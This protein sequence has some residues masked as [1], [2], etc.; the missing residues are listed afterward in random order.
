MNLLSTNDAPGLDQAIVF[1]KAHGFDVRPDIAVILGSGL[2]GFEERLERAIS[3]PYEAIPGF[4][5]VTVPGH[6]GRLYCGSIADKTALVFAG[7]FHR[8]EGHDMATSVLPVALA[9]ALGVRSL[10]VSNAAG[11]IN[12][13]YRVGDLM[14]ITGCLSLVQTGG[15]RKYFDRARPQTPLSLSPVLRRAAAEVDVDLFEGNYLYVTG[16]SYETPAEVRAFRSLGADA[17]G[18]STVP[19][20]AAATQFGLRC[21]AVSL[22]T[23][24]ASGMSDA[25]LDHADIKDVGQR[26]TSDFSRLVEAFIRLLP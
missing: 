5:G 26:R 2:G 7:R 8:Y 25:V 10:F 22:I 15:G 16:P 19:E 12:A 17:V 6:S 14:E 1:L 23:N 9:A 3:V 11:G 21:A 20:L 24:A 13:D 4:P 18:M